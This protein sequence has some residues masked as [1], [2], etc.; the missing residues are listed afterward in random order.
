MTEKV[1]HN[2]FGSGKI[3][4]F[5]TIFLNNQPPVA[6]TIGSEV[7]KGKVLVIGVDMDDVS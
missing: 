7:Q 2:I 6:D 4:N 5:W 1:S 3:N